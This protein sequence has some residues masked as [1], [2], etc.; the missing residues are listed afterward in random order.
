[1]RE[2]D[3]NKHFQIQ[4]LESYRLNDLAVALAPGIEPGLADSKSAHLV[5]AADTKHIISLTRF[6]FPLTY[7][8]GSVIPK[9]IEHQHCGFLLTQR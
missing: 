5:F 3:S 2:L 1:L 8:C 7:I 9:D 4:N 6:I